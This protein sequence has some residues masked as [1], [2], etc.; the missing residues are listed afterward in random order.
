MYLEILV[1]YNG[2]LSPF[3]VL[4]NVLLLYHKEVNLY[5]KKK[6]IFCWKKFK[7]S[8]DAIK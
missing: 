4:Q 7:T 2:I 1:E 6:V 5:I 8:G 3:K